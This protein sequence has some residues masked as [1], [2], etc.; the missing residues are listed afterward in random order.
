MPK[1]RARECGN[2]WSLYGRVAAVGSVEMREMLRKG[3]GM[4]GKMPCDNRWGRGI[5][6]VKDATR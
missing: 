4:A 1:C 3:T 5:C 6:T 2:A